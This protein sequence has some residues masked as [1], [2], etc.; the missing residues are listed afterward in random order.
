MTK[1][2][3]GQL[4]LNF[5]IIA[6]AFKFDSVLSEWHFVKHNIKAPQLQNIMMYQYAISYLVLGVFFFIVM[7]IIYADKYVQFEEDF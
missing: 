4:L 2:E 3:L 1:R 7:Y 6:S 5:I